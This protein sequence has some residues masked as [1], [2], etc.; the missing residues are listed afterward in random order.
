MIIP[1][2]YAQ[3]NMIFTGP[4]VPTGAECTVGFD[5]TA[6]PSTPSAAAS[7]IATIIEGCTQLFSAT[8][9]DI[10]MSTLL[11]KFGPNATGPSAVLAVDFD[12]TYASTDGAPATAYLIRKNTAMGG[13]QGRGRLYW[14]GPPLVDIGPGGVIESNLVGDMNTGFTEFFTE[15]AAADMPLVLLRAEGSPITT[16]EPLTGFSCQTTLATQRRRQRR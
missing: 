10:K 9:T 14:P 5:R 2:G 7:E 12:G 3:L 16:P 6:G 15:M 8:K 11:V 1:T 13:R 4:S